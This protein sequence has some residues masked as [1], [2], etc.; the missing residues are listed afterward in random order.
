M[1]KRAETQEAVETKKETKKYLVSIPRK[2]SHRQD[3]RDKKRNLIKTY[4]FV[5]IM[6]HEEMMRDH[7]EQQIAQLP[8]GSV[9]AKPGDVLELPLPDFTET[10]TKN[11][12]ET[13]QLLRSGTIK[14]V[15]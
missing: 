15:E 1:A 3:I 8:E 9:V 13:A 5:D 2:S 4:F 11:M 7:F 14:E 10:P 12:N 6:R